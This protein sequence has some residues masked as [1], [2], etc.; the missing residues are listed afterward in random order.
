MKLNLHDKVVVV[1]GASQGIGAA[2]AREFAKNGSRVVLAARSI[3][4]IRQIA[5]E[6]NDSGGKAFP[7]KTD[8]SNI[9]EIKK[10]CK[11]AQK[12]YGTV[13]VWINNAG[14]SINYD[15]LFAREDWVKMIFNVN[16]NAVFWGM[17]TATHAM[18]L[19]QGTPRG[20]I[21]NISSLVSELPVF[22]KSTLYTA[23]KNAVDTLSEGACMELAPLD[24][25]VINV[26]PGFTSTNFH[27][28]RKGPKKKVDINKEGY[29]F[30]KSV[31]P[32]VVAKKIVNS[33][34]DCENNIRVIITLRDRLS[35]MMI[36][37]FSP[38]VR[39]IM[40]KTSINNKP[41]PLM[42]D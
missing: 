12:K 34:R 5:R 31:G 42:K 37:P 41:D 2:M 33:V 6:I 11:T 29:L 36:K 20:V 39:W 18:M 10:L 15:S 26:K 14:F 28:N 17:R 8:V 27:V 21:V 35:L 19:N 9:N 25:R 30:F 40:N 24:I 4:L 1:T 32:E 16:F 7:V 3:D 38:L 23:T 22:P 13:D